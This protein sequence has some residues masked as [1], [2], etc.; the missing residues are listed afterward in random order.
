MFYVSGEIPRVTSFEH[1]FPGQHRQTEDGSWE[2]DPL[3]MDERW[4][5]A[6]VKDKGLVVFTACSHAGVVNV[7][8]HARAAFPMCH[9]M[10]S[11]AGSISQVGTRKSLPKRSRR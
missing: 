10:R 5:A 11:S 7:L 9:S 8:K 6:N 2:P 4:V 1:G 3:L